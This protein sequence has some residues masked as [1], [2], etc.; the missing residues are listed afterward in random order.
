MPRTARVVGR[1]GLPLERLRAPVGLRRLR[2]G[3]QRVIRSTADLAKVSM[4]NAANEHGCD[5][6]QSLDELII[7]VMPG[8]ARC[9]TLCVCVKNLH[10]L[11]KL[12]PHS[13][14]P[15]LMLIAI[16]LPLLVLTGLVFVPLYSTDRALGL[17]MMI[18]MIVAGRFFARWLPVMA[19]VCTGCNH[20]KKI[21]FG[22]RVPLEWKNHMAFRSTC[23]LCGYS[24]VGLHDNRCPECGDSFPAAWLEATR[25]G[26]AC[27]EIRS[28]VIRQ[29]ASGDR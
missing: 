4:E 12:N 1:G 18:A 8:C 28:V 24:I 22:K 27:R 13:V 14:Y 15:G 20:V 25:K 7:P 9:E 2:H 19:L 3:E 6:E 17:V 23:M 21:R 29:P 5:G 10:D 16:I 11:I 26:V